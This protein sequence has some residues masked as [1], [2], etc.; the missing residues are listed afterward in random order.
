MK[1]WVNADIQTK[2]EAFLERVLLLSK[3][4]LNVYHVFFVVSGNVMVLK[5]T[6]FFANKTLLFL[7]LIFLLVFIHVS[8]AF[9]F[10]SSFDSSNVQSFNNKEKPQKYLPCLIVLV[11]SDNVHTV[12]YRIFVT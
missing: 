3:E 12:D 8:F 7:F 9:R 6:S 5:Q 10:V 2:M 4:C 11:S 1:K